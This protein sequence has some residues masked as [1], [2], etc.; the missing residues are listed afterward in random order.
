[1][2]I[3]QQTKLNPTH[4]TIPNSRSCTSRTWQNKLTHK[5]PIPSFTCTI[6]RTGLNNILGGQKNLQLGVLTKNKSI[7]IIT[8]TT[9]KIVA[10]V[11]IE[12]LSV[13]SFNLLVSF[14]IALLS[15]MTPQLLFF[16]FF[17]FV[18]PK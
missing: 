2:G 10:H 16:F 8:T 6:M 12:V 3:W 11:I 14:K 4:T 15:F 5:L 7:T 9:K 13:T 1:M 18:P 17:C